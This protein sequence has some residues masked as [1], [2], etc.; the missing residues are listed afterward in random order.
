MSIL[1]PW[2]V[3]GTHPTPNDSDGY[4]WAWEWDVT[5]ESAFCSNIWMGK[6]L[7]D[8]SDWAKASF[9]RGPSLPPGEE[10]LS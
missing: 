5:G 6:L 7:Y 4:E 2:E 3:G 10:S 9:W 1:S 8:T